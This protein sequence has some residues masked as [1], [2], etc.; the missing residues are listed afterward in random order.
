M[1]SMCGGRISDIFGYLE[2]GHVKSFRERNYRTVVLIW[3]SN[4]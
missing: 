1:Y 4:E 3:C 2:L